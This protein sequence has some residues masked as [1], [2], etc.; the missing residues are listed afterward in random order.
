[1]SGM[2]PHPEALY[3]HVAQNAVK[4]ARGEAD[5]FR[6][7]QAVATAM[8]F[9]ALCLEAFINQEY[10]IHPEICKVLEDGDRLPLSTKWLLLPLLLGAEATFNKGASPFQTFQE[11]VWNRNQRLVHFKPQQEMHQ[12]IYFGDLV[13][14]VT[15]AELY[16]N[17]VGDMIRELN[18]ISSGKTSLPPFLTGSEYLSEVWVDAV[19]PIEWRSEEPEPGKDT[20]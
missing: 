1:M 5:E 4:A 3:Y 2:R 13:N 18:R 19:I 16:A 17:C 11:L 10:M 15:R 14:D 12:K 6:R 9:S 7:K 20:S 8:V